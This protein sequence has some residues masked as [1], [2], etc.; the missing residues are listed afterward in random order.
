LPAPPAQA[1]RRVSRRRL[2]LIGALTL[3]CLLAIVAGWAVAGYL[4]VSAGVDAANKR[5]PDSARAA[6]TRPTGSLL[7]APTD[8]LLLGTD[9][10]AVPGRSGDR[11][12]DSIMLLRTDPSRHRLEYLSLPRD[13]L[14]TVPGYGQ[15]KINAA[16]QFGGPAL[17]IKTIAA[18]TGLPINHVA[19]V[20][21]ASFK[22]LIDAIG[23]ITVN[24]PERIVSDEFDC[25][26]S[27]NQCQHW[28]GW[29]FAK[30][31]QQ[32]NGE[33]AL[34]YSRIRVNRLNPAD[35]DVTRALHQQ[36]VMQAVLSKLASPSTFASLPF[37][38]GA[39][40][41]PL[42]TDLSTLDFVELAWIKLRTSTTLHCRLG[43]T[44]NGNGYLIPDP[45]ANSEVIRELL[46]R[47]P[48]RPPSIS[49]GLYAPGCVTGNRPF[50]N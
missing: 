10:A 26:Y 48:P 12:S 50:P 8:V 42:A 9:N 45:T 43:G 7:S 47:A 30:G 11:H 34:V 1:P 35:S 41:K 23:G 4:S 5:L 19:V 6:L 25:P 16:M 31:P 22:Q 14:T 18:F 33:R 38:G 37:D 17:A 3:A 13:L 36:Q 28:L 32:M 46:D 27:T 2:L 29:R 44:S 39:L 40:L 20:N 21:F 24:V 15:Q 49:E